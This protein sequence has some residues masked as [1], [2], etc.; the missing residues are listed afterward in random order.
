MIAIRQSMQ[1]DDKRAQELGLISEEFAFY[2]TVAANF[3]TVY[4]PAFLRDLVH[5]LVQTLKP[6]LKIDWTEPSCEEIRARV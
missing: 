5:D 2:D 4:D 1:S 6:N 3:M